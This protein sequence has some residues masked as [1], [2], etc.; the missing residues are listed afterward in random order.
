MVFYLGVVRN[1]FF[2]LAL[3]SFCYCIEVWVS[4][5]DRLESESDQLLAVPGAA[6]LTGVRENLVEYIYH[7]VH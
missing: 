2:R 5:G 4:V 6:Y 3:T 7:G 1:F